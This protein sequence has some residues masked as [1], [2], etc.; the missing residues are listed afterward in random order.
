[1]VDKENVA[2]TFVSAEN[3]D[4]DKEAR[5]IVS[6]FLTPEFD[7]LKRFYKSL[8]SFQITVFI[9]SGSFKTDP[10]TSIFP[11]PSCPTD[12]PSEFWSRVMEFG[13]AAGMETDCFPKKIPPYLF[14][15]K[16][17]YGNK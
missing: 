3:V 10:I 15:F 11:I 9:R 4:V 8:N 16:V 12:N 17:H 13:K 6:E 7:K 1:M 5:K 14:S 2:G